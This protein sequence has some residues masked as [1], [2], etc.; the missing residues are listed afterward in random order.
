MSTESSNA[1]FWDDEFTYLDTEEFQDYAAAI[2]AIVHHSD[3]PVGTRLIHDTLGDRARREW[4]LDALSSLKSVEVIEGYID[5]WHPMLGVEPVHSKRW[6]GQRMAW[7]F[8]R[9]R[10]S[11]GFVDLGVKGFSN[12]GLRSPNISKGIFCK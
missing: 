9:S 1:P 10:K 2:E 7:L 8:A 12:R 3:G 11:A 6:S 4:T 5:R